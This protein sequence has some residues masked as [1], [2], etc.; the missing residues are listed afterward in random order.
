[1]K[2]ITEVQDLEGKVIKQ[3][4]LKGYCKTLVL[5]FEDG[6]YAVV[7]SVIDSDVVLSR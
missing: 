2:L 6:T 3:A 4:S 7:A 1:M 5:I